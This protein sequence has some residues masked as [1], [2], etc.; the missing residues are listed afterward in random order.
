MGGAIG[1]DSQ[2]ENG[3]TFWFTVR[4]SRQPAEA[5]ED[6]AGVSI[7]DARLFF[8]SGGSAANEWLVRTA[9]EQHLHYA[10]F[11]SID[12]AI[13]TARQ[14]SDW[15]LCMLIV[16]GDDHSIL[17]RDIPSAVRRGGTPLPCVLIHPDVNEI[18]AFDAG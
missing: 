3:T 6:G 9:L 12:D 4:L 14:D 18:D 16:D 13:T 7:R 2:P 1:F 11:P 5:Y 8:I 10:S 17:W 15:E